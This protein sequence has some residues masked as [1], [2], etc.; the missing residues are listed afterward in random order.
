[1][2]RL[3]DLRIAVLARAVSLFGDELALVALLLRTQGQGHGA[4]PVVALLLAGGLP[5]VLLAPLVGSLVDRFD[6]RR[7]LL[8]SGCGQL[9][10]C[11]ALA[12]LPSQPVILALV[13]ALGAGQAVNSATWQALLP[14]IVGVDRLPAALGI[15][16]ATS[17]VAGIAAPAIAG[18]LTGL[19]GA[20][21]PLLL[22]AVSFT[23]VV[24]AALTIRT[25]RGSLAGRAADPRGG[26][27]GRGADRRA[28]GRPVQWRVQWPAEAAA[29]G[30]GQRGRALAQPGRDG[31]GSDGGLAAARGAGR[32][33]VQRAT[34]PGHR[35]AGRPPGRRSRSGPGGGG[36][37]WAGFGGP[38][39][40]PAARR[41]AGHRPRTPADLR[42]SRA[43]RAAGSGR[44][45][46]PAAGVHQACVHQ[47]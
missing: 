2:W 1:L 13:A 30:P 44:G 17:T 6:S 10:C 4:W 8:V 36:G 32:R 18:V 23:A 37:R 46:T 35:L 45:G 28:A 25:R 11:L 31:P 7:L 26:W 34:Q 3:R 41:A 12:G 39:G 27:G 47:G 19:Y 29:A 40:R 42:A 9:V 21:L 22:D 16:Q 5:L 43:A 14:S 33:P 15:S 24:L 20:R 38:G